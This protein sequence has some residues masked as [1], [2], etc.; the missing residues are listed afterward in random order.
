MEA[1]RAYTGQRNKRIQIVEYTTTK[2]ALGAPVKTPVSIGY[3]FAAMNDLS[4]RETEEGKVVYVID[5]TY[6]IPY[7]SDIKL[8]GEQMVLKDD[9]QD[10]Q[11]YHVAELGRKSQLILKCTVR[12]KNE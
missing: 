5:R 1:K 8:R 10:F 3:F 11:I 6:T 2:D 9:D 12:K 4:G 7:Q